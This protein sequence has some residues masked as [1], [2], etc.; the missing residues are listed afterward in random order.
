M[1]ETARFSYFQTII[2][3]DLFNAILYY[4]GLSN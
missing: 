4:P 3:T 1:G 2:H